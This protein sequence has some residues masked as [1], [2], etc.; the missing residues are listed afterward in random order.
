MVS[1]QGWDVSCKS[2][3]RNPTDF[4]SVGSRGPDR[5]KAGHSEQMRD[6]DKEDAV[7]KLNCRSGQTYGQGMRRH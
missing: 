5:E 1:A 3:L 4:S 2:K 7:T 6:T